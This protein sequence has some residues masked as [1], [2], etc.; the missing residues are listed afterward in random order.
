MTYKILLV[1]I[2]ARN[3]HFRIQDET[4]FKAMEEDEITNPST[5]KILD[6]GSAIYSTKV[7]L[8]SCDR[9]I[10]AKSLLVLCDFGEAR[11]GKDTYEDES[12]Q[13][14]EYRAPEVFLRLPWS[15][16]VDIWSF[17]CMV[18]DP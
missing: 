16:P 7:Y 2:S 11:T 10:G 3:I 5:R 15:T 6:D 13:P 17:G 18:G 4:I 8:T 1:D 12:A 14:H 9:W